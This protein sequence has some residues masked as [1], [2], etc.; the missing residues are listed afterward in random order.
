MG[1]LWLVQGIAKKASIAG[2]R[3]CRIQDQRVCR[4]PERES[5]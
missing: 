1:C 4:G 5:E 3:L 2:W